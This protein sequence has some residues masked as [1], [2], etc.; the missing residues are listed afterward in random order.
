MQGSDWGVLLQSF[1]RWYRRKAAQRAIRHGVC[2]DCRS[3][4]SKTK[5]CFT[6]LYGL[7]SVENPQDR[8]VLW[9]SWLDRHPQYQLSGERPNQP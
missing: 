6:C 3:N 4:P 7:R 1:V 2:P 5:T 8:V 9:E